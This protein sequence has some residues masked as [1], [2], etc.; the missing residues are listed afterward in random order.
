MYINAMLRGF[1]R[2]DEDHWN[3]AAIALF[4]NG[5]VFDIHFMEHGAGF[6]KQGCDGPL[7]FFA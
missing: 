6:A 7:S 4:Q 2:A 3:V 5:V 1:A